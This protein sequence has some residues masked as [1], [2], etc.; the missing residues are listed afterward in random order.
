MGP[1]CCLCWYK[2]SS[3]S[4]PPPPLLTQGFQ[5]TK[6]LPP[7][8]SLPPSL[9]EG[10]TVA[11]CYPV[12]NSNPL[13]LYEPAV[14]LRIRAACKQPRLS[15]AERSSLCAESERCFCAQQVSETLFRLCQVKKSVE[16]NLLDLKL[17]R[18]RQ[19]ADAVKEEGGEGLSESPQ[20]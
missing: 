17:K 3:F 1:G 14:C 2:N 15:L 6:Q 5:D 20:Q 19:M 8:L 12:L 11:V 16:N 10:C 9:T 7:S 18:R 13:R 4:A